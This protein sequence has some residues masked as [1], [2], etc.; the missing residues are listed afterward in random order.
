MWPFEK[1]E[2]PVRG[3]TMMEAELDD[4]V[5]R[6]DNMNDGPNQMVQNI[7]EEIRAVVG[8]PN[9]VISTFS[10]PLITNVYVINTKDREI[11]YSYHDKIIIKE[12]K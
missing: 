10:V 1:K 7:F 5:L 6:Y 9:A 2:P 4:I 11:F 8:D 3:R 12:K